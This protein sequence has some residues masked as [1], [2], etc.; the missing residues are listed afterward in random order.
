MQDF[1]RKEALDS[2]SATSTMTK[3]VRAVSVKAAVFTLLLALCAAAFGVW[4]VLGTVYETVSVSGVIWPAEGNGSV[5]ASSSGVVAKTAVSPGDSVKTGDLLAVVPQEELLAKIEAG[6]ESGIADEE[7]TRLYEEYDRLSMV[8]SQIDGV[9]TGVVSENTYVEN[10]DEVAT[11]MPLKEGGNNK[12]LTAFIPSAQSDLVALGMEVQVMP[13]FAPRETYGYIKAYVSGVSSYPVTGQSIKERSGV[14]FLPELDE[15]ESYI[16]LEITLISD[17][18]TQSRLKWSNP[19]SG[20]V[21]VST[22]T[23]CGA[24]I[25]VNKCP[26][27]QWLFRS[28]R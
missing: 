9:V 19:G 7:L 14:L 11:V 26:P 6:K 4:L 12:V 10:G 25:V 3:S 2:F 13:A 16:Q 5:Y 21:D 1:F 28:A 22:G 24:D 8:R 27:Y 18:S 23:V 17:A 15:R 20:N